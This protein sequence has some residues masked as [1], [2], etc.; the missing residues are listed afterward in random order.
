MTYLVTLA[1]FVA[2]ML[3]V[4][5]IMEHIE[6]CAGCGWPFRDSDQRVEWEGH[7]KRIPYHVTCWARMADPT[8]RGNVDDDGDAGD[9]LDVPGLGEA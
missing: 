1:V 3:V 4:G 8:D 2:S 5:G 7:G 6:T 9:P